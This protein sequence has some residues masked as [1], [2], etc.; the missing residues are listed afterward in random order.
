MNQTEPHQ[1]SLAQNIALEYP[2][3]HLNAENSKPWNPSG[4]FGRLSLFAWFFVV[5][6]IMLIAMLV[7]IGPALIPLMQGSTHTQ[8]SPFFAVSMFLLIPLSILVTVLMVIFMIRRLH[9]LNKS[10]HYLWLLLASSIFMGVGTVSQISQLQKMS[11]SNNLSNP[12]LAIYGSPTVWVPLLFMY[13]FT[14]YLFLAPGTKGANRFGA[15]R[16]TPTWEAIV[17]WIYIALQVVGFVLSITSVIS[18]MRPL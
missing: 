10:G 14:F 15:V 17:G 11:A 9:D 12:L 4:R 13:A 16:A 3:A 1:P 6:A 5:Y 2:A 8:P 18:M 7:L